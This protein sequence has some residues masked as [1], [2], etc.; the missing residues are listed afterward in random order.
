MVVSG[1]AS[2]GIRLAAVAR[3][4]YITAGAS[5]ISASTRSVADLQAR[6]A[7]GLDAADNAGVRYVDAA[8]SAPRSSWNQL[9][10]VGQTDRQRTLR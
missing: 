5:A 2:L 10:D 7:Q 4:A 8:R 6:T 9:D 3:P 1:A